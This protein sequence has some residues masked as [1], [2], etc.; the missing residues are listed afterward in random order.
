VTHPAALVLGE[1]A[2]ELKAL[3]SRVGEGA[4]GAWQASWARCREIFARYQAEAP[5]LGALSTGERASLTRA[6]D[7]VVRLNAVAAGLVA[8]ETERIADNLRQVVSSKR[9]VREQSD[10]QDTADMGGNCDVRG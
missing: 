10:V 9:R 3:L 6:V 4:D 2:T 8:R 5:D 1:L 7:E